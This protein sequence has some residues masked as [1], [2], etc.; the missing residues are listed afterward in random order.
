MNKQALGQRGEVLAC[1]YLRSTG[2]HIVCTNYR[3]R[4]GEIDIIAI[5]DG[6]LTFVEVK[7]RTD[8][9]LG[10]PAEAIT[11]SK[12][13][14]F[15]ITVLE[16]LQQKEIPAFSDMKFDAITILEYPGQPPQ[17]ELFEHILGP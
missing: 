11:K 8:L 16:Y 17:L 12:L 15:R 6:V 2:H 13:S 14:K 1:D 9:E 7:Y 5:K 4:R 10:H 3:T